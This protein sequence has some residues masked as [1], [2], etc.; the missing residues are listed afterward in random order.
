MLVLHRYAR[1]MEM[2]GVRK[3][4]NTVYYVLRKCLRFN[5]ERILHTLQTAG[6]NRESID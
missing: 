6:V 3:N 5:T 4:I 2:F 1:F